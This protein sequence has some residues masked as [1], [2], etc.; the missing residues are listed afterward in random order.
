MPDVEPAGTDFDLPRVKLLNEWMQKHDVMTFD[1]I[2][3]D[4]QSSAFTTGSS[5]ET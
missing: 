4:E 1:D 5:N 2:A 3:G